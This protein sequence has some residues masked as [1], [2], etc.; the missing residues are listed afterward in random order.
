MFELSETLLKTKL[1]RVFL[2]CGSGKLSNVY[3]GL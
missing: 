2:P 3:E 1:P